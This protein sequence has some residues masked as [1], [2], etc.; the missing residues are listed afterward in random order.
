MKTPQ[1]TLRE[2]IA[3]CQ[4]PNPMR[5]A[6][7]DAETVEDDEI[8][9]GLRAVERRDTVSI[10]WPSIAGFAAALLVAGYAYWQIVLA[11]K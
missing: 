8:D 5:F 4:R 7:P 10:D 11:C 6:E 3:D 1:E 9:A 2:I